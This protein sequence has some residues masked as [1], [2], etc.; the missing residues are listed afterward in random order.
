MRRWLHFA[1]ASVATITFTDSSVD[2]TDLTEYT[3]STQAIGDAAADR[4]VVVCVHGGN[5]DATVASLTVGG[6]SAD[7][8]VAKASGVGGSFFNENEIWQAI[9]PTGTTADVVVTWSAGQ[10]ECHI[11][12]FAVY[13]AQ[14][15]A[16]ATATDITDP[17]S[18][19]L[20]VPAGGVAIAFASIEEVRTFTWGAGI[21]EQFDQTTSSRA[22]STGA[23]DAYA[24]DTTVTVAATPS[25]STTKII[26]V[27]A[28]WGP[29]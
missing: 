17:L 25:S 21:T 7:L 15:A 19:S 2:Q 27:A 24:A 18:Q 1:A 20:A 8:V 12:I 3:F 23:S 13:G 6:I 10:L 14:S 22:T 5:N 9:V 29:A 4:K 28:S 16:H 11:G 26:L